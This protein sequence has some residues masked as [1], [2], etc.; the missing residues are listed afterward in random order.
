MRWLA[1]TGLILLAVAFLWRRSSAKSRATARRRLVRYHPDGESISGRRRSGGHLDKLITLFERTRYVRRLKSSLEASGL[2]TSW[3]TFRLAWMWLLFFVPSLAFAITA[4][5]FSVPSAAFAALVLPFPALEALR[6]R[7]ARKR[8]EDVGRF[9]SELALVLR[10]GVPVEDAISG[11]RADFDECLGDEL[12]RFLGEISLGAVPDEALLR[13]VAELEDPDVEL[14]AQ[15]AATSRQTGSD[16]R[17]VM[18]SV[19]ETVRERAAIRRELEAQT[20]QGRLS[21]KIVAALPFV[22]LC[23]SALVSRGTLQVL[24]GT[25]PGIIMLCSAVMMDAIAFLWIRKI[26]YVRS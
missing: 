13:L 23:L 20:V 15:A 10:C 24:F 7:R 1:V 6:R 8:A 21:G 16:V 2:P 3:P 18:E 22:F 5:P 11:C 14:I 9:A 19:G 4:S 25:V 26:L 17:T 12:G